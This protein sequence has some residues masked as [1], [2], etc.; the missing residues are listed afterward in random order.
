MRKRIVKVEIEDSRT[1]PL[2]LAFIMVH[3]DNRGRVRVARR[4]AKLT[5]RNGMM[6]VAKRKTTWT[7][8]V[9][10]QDSVE[11]RNLL[12]HRHH[13]GKNGELVLE[14]ESSRCNNGGGEVEV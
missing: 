5:H 12:C 10:V 1:F 13:G 3:I 11:V 2:N 14:G 9:D 6:I 7:G 8:H 4:R